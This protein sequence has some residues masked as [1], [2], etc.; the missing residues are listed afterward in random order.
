M[1][2]LLLDIDFK[3]FPIATNSRIIHK[4]KK[5]IQIS[6]IEL[7]LWMR[8]AFRKILPRIFSKSLEAMSSLTKI[9]RFFVL[10][11]T[12]IEISTSKLTCFFLKFRIANERLL[13]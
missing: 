5:K 9:H 2:D 10:V 6:L 12:W 4:S 1:I 7:K 8:D 11:A 3:T 13:S